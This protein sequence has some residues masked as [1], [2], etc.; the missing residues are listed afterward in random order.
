MDAL[1]KIAVSNSDRRIFGVCGGLARATE[2]PAWM[3]RAG[4]V[5]SLL[6]GGLGGVLYLVLGYFMP[7][8]HD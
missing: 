2:V 8:S 7:A 5:M 4:F 6:F 1:K 3:W